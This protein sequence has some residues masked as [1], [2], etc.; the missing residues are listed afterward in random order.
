LQTRLF[1]LY[2]NSTNTGPKKAGC[3]LG[4][5]AFLLISKKM[6]KRQVHN[7]DTS[8]LKHTSGGKKKARGNVD[9]HFIRKIRELVKITFPSIT[10]KESLLVAFLIGLLVIRTGL[11]I[12][13]S[14]V[15]GL[16]VKAIMKR[17]LGMFIKRIFVLF[18]FAFPSCLV[19]SLMEYT[20]K[21][22]G[23]N[24]R[25][26]MTDY[27]H[28]RYLNQLYY[29]KICNLDTRIPNP[30]QRL[31][32]DLEK[33]SNSLS[34]LILNFMK[35]LLDIVM[36]TRKLV[37]LIGV[38]GPLASLG[39]YFISGVIIRFISPEFGKLTA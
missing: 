11:S 2:K 38:Q 6:M 33:W 29:Y 27:F 35:P 8:K 36:F 12:W 13:L 20:T 5:G 37:D 14:D 32:Q 26:R 21:L 34:S 30:D 39:W 19:N 22:L 24:F 25:K 31:T 16:I 28:K 3:V 10:C 9:R 17:D 15:N 18:L 7:L 4:F 23:I 1:E